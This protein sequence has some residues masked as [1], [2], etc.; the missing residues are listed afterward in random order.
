MTTA[1]IRKKL[2]HYSQFGDSKKIRALYTLLEDEIEAS[3]SFDVEFFKEMDRR[4]KSMKDGTAKMYTLEDAL[5]AA[6]DRVKT[7]RK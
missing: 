4:I 3:A 5:Q 7:K 1:A 2:A 6:R